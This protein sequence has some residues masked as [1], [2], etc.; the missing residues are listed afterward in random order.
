MTEIWH[1][2]RVEKLCELHI[3]QGQG[4]PGIYICA[5]IFLL[6]P[7]VVSPVKFLGSGDTPW[8]RIWVV[9]AGWAMFK[10]TSGPSDLWD[11]KSVQYFCIFLVIQSQ[12]CEQSRIHGALM[13]GKVNK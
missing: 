7:F 9:M 1:S 5:K 6:F 4:F 10:L 12:M 8:L 3:R 11:I 2:K 13:V